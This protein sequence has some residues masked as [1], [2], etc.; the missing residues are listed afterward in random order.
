MIGRQLALPFSHV[1]HLTAADFLEAPSN[2]EA[3]IWLS[4]TSDWPAARLALSGAAGVGKTHLLHM[5]RDR[6][7]AR[8]LDGAALAFEPPAT[9]LAIDD[10][11][12]APPEA[13]LH[14]LNAAAEAGQPVLLA[15]RAPP[16]QWPVG[17]P[18]LSSR[19]RA[20]LAVAIL[21]PEESLLRALLMKLLAERQLAVPEPVQEWML[22]RL[23]RTAASLRAA[24]IR[25]DRASLRAGRSAPR[26]IAAEVVADMEGGPDVLRDDEDF[27]VVADLA[28]HDAALLL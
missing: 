6:V 1:P 19:L 26:A 24:A 23:P 28:S 3:L 27:A 8:L 20:I 5:W 7:A 14:V 25:F 12:A 15:A 21:P 10:A 11:D 17:L 2:A 16:A 22:T 4:R 9:P 18:D 13:L